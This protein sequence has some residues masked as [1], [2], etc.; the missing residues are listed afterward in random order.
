MKMDETQIIKEK[1][2]KIRSMLKVNSGGIPSV[3][4]GAVSCIEKEIT[5]LESLINDVESELAI[6]DSACEGEENGAIN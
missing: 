4:E 3:Q 1:L 2:I 5:E 6:W